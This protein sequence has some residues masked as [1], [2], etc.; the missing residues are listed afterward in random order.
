MCKL[1][2]GTWDDL[3]QRLRRCG[4]SGDAD[5]KPYQ[6]A[7]ISMERIRIAELVPT[8]KYVLEE[9]L[10][11][12]GRLNDRLS[13]LGVDIF[14]LE[15][16]ILW[17]DGREER[18]IACPIIEHWPG[19]GLLLVDG[20]HRV[21]VARDLGR[22]ELVCAVIRHVEVPLVPLPIKWEE[23]KVFP[24]GQYPLEQ[25]KRAYRFPN[26]G[27][28]RTALPSISHKVTE[29]NF[30]YFLYRN[31]EDLGSSGIRPPRLAIR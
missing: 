21:W 27:S 29:G 23:V 4:T 18:P 3:V 6:S 28:L 24:V 19:E 8:A 16:G 15:C 20:F 2:R 25:D 10:R 17:P 11:T 30:R 22:A 5:L 14:D 31:L 1:E 26:A 12:V 9:G 7:D 13:S